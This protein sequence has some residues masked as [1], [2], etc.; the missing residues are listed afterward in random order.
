MCLSKKLVLIDACGVLCHI[1]DPPGIALSV[2]DNTFS[3]IDHPSLLSTQ[4]CVSNNSLKYSIHEP[5]DAGTRRG[6]K[7]QSDGA[8]NLPT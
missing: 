3:P 4:L 2:K 7:W 5:F 6:M 8:A 1:K